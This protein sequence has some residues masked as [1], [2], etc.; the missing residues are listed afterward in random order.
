M[1]NKKISVVLP[2][3]NEEKTILHCINSAT[4]GINK[5]NLKG[6]VIVADNGSSDNSI[7]IATEAN[8]KIVH[9]K[10]KG[11]GSALKFAC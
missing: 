8:A 10:N 4:S 11:Y 7:K 1:K 5:S 6:E 2:C 9:V 3:L